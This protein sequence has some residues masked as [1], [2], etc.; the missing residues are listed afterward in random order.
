MNRGSVSTSSW[1][2]EE[3]ARGPTGGGNSNVSAAPKGGTV[4]YF[5]SPPDPGWGEGLLDER[6]RTEQCDERMFRTRGRV[7]IADL[8]RLHAGHAVRGVPDEDIPDPRGFPHAAERGEPLLLPEVRIDEGIRDVAR[9]VEIV[10]TE[11]PR[12]AL[13]RGIEPWQGRV[14]HDTAIL[15]RAPQSQPVAGVQLR[16]MGFRTPKSRDDPLRQVA[17]HVGNDYVRNRAPR[18]KMPAHA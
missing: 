2:T 16:R 18:A 9:R 5:P 8:D 12:G 10:K 7:A 11:L 4:S 13:D 17:V 1:S 14:D 6:L 15:H 3:T